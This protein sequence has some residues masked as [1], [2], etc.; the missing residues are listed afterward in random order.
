MLR[1]ASSDTISRRTCLPASASALGLEGDGNRAMAA[2]RFAEFSGQN[3]TGR[4]RV[5]QRLAAQRVIHRWIEQ[6]PAMRIESAD[7]DTLR[8]EQVD[9]DRQGFAE[10]L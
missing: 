6:L 7:H 1:H 4:T 3:L 8:I 5:R 9:D 2:D 10:P